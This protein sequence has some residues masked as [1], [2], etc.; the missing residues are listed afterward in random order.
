MDMTQDDIKEQARGTAAMTANGEGGVNYMSKGGRALTAG[1]RPED[2]RTDWAGP[3]YWDGM[4]ECHT[5]YLWAACVFTKAVAAWKCFG[6]SA[7]LQIHR[8]LPPPL[9]ASPPR[10]VQ[11]G[12]DEDSS[13]KANTS[14]AP[15]HSPISSDTHS[16]AINKLEACPLRSTRALQ[17]SSRHWDYSLITHHSTAVEVKADLKY[18]QQWCWKGAWA[19]WN[20]VFQAGRVRYRET[21]L[22][23]DGHNLSALEQDNLYQLQGCG[24]ELGTQNKNSK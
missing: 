22:Q 15:S 7:R 3:G 8:P 6:S 14:L 12:W 4:E 24:S 5:C 1:D 16:G 19:V 2:L 13:P 21:F 17:S 11:S 20:P 18:R 10:W 9:S 23:L